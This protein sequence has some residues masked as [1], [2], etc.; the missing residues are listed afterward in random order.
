M[1]NSNWEIIYKSVYLLYIYLVCAYIGIYGRFSG[2]IF[3]LKIFK[4][5]CK[6]IIQGEFRKSWA[7]LFDSIIHFFLEIQPFLLTRTK[8]V[9]SNNFLGIGDIKFVS[10]KGGRC[11]LNIY[12]MK[13]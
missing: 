3:L 8:L 7:S 10:V 13:N 2:N 4:V 5:Y 6:D 12:R 9:M 1:D 11:M